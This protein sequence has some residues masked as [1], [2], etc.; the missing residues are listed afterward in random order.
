[1]DR[2]TDSFAGFGEGARLT[3]DNWVALLLTAS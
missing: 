1:V 2:I 3:E